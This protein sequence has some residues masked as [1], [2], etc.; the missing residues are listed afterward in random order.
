MKEIICN[1][2]QQTTGRVVVVSGLDE[3]FTKNNVLGI[4][5]KTQSKV[6]YTP[7]QATNMLSASYQDG[8]ITIS[9]ADNVPNINK[10]D[11]LL[12][13][14]YSDKEIVDTTELAKQGENAEATNS[15]IYDEV[16]GI[17]NTFD[18][19]DIP[20]SAIS[21]LSLELEGGKKNIANALKVRGI[22]SSVNTDTLTDMAAKV[23][24]I[25]NPIAFTVPAETSN[26]WANSFFN[27]MMR[28]QGLDE[29][30]A[31]VYE[32]Y[33]GE[34]GSYV[35]CLMSFMEKTKDTIEL[36]GADAYYIW[37]EETYYITGTNG[38]LQQ[39]ING[40]LVQ[41]SS[42]IHTWDSNDKRTTRCVFYLYETNST[43]NGERELL[44]NCIIDY[45]K[46]SI[47]PCLTYAVNSGIYVHYE[48]ENIDECDLK[49]LSTTDNS[50]ILYFYCNV[51][52]CRYNSS[53][54][55]TRAGS[56]SNLLFWDMPNLKKSSAY[57][58]NGGKMRTINFDNL[59]ELAGG[60]LI[61]TFRNITHLKFPKLKTIADN[62]II[63]ATSDLLRSSVCT[64]ELPV[65]ERIVYKLNT[66]SGT[67]T[68]APDIV[69]V[70]L[71]D[72]VTIGFLFRNNALD[73]AATNIKEL[74]VT[75]KE[76]YSIPLEE[77]RGAQYPN[78]S[79]EKIFFN[80]LKK[81]DLWFGNGAGATGF[82]KYIYINCIGDRE[83]EIIMKA[84][85]HDGTCLVSDIELSQ[86]AR[87]P[88]NFTGMLR[89]TAANIVNHIFDRLADNRFEDDGVT[90]APAITITLGSDN[91]AKLTDAQKAIA[92]NKNYILA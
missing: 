11:E 2:T 23:Y 91:L 64:I 16:K 15:K 63:F 90:P 1:I 82:S 29:I 92:T 33:C 75:C 36:K 7:V 74:H 25:K 10:G 19:L 81:C 26:E 4:I 73:N 69:N 31:T 80:G 46:D 5:N 24:D 76:I 72:G 86:G 88:F 17:K 66:S 44:H 53:T 3:E 56:A 8:T 48:V 85:A 40:S 83:D 41:L 22:E 77:M 14:L 59:E 55:V 70:R 27:T 45:C 12:V 68:K 49:Y 43:A 89:L 62:S 38:N 78:F 21:G 37:E 30:Y 32:T 47:I 61:S 58:M 60:Q 67:F 50:R 34:N 6:L 79:G 20:L 42:K 84:G 39:F 52:E 13:K 51:T 65:C 35:G 54:T 57:L 71:K 28:S 18:I 9:L 87:Q